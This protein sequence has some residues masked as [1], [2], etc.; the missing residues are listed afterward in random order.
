MAT[1]ATADLVEGRQGRRRGSDNSVGQRAG[2]GVCHEVLRGSSSRGWSADRAREAGL[3]RAR[4]DAEHP[5]DLRDR[6]VLDVVQQE[7][8]AVLDG[9]AG[10][11]GV[12][13]DPG[14]L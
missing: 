8:G 5:R 11:R 10:E 2:E 12:Q 14:V 4:G 3:D 6:E 9:Q 7:R 13:V 1:G